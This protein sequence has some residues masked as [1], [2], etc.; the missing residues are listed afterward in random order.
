MGKTYKE[1]LIENQLLQERIPFKSGVIPI[2]LGVTSMVSGIKQQCLVLNELK[3]LTIKPNFMITSPDFEDLNK[4]NS[5]V[6]GKIIIAA[7]AQDMEYKPM[8]KGTC[9]IVSYFFG[10]SKP[11][12]T[13]DFLRRLSESGFRI[14]NIQGLSNFSSEAILDIS[15]K[16]KEKFERIRRDERT[17]KREKEEYPCRIRRVK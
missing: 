15:V 3:F 5:G 8:E 7:K 12:R 10:R 13:F 1:V 6:M 2:E 9:K 16:D 14:S 4:P 17:V 11:N